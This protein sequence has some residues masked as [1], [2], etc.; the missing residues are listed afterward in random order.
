[1]LT[2]QFQFQP[3]AIIELD[4]VVYAVYFDTESL[5]DFPILA[6]VDSM[7]FVKDPSVIKKLENEEEFASLYGYVFRGHEDLLVSEIPTLEPGQEAVEYRSVMDTMEAKLD[8]KGKEEGMAWILDRDVQ[9]AFLAATLTGQPIS[10]D[11]L[12]DTAWYNMST[13]GQRNFMAEFYADNDAFQEKVANNISS[14]RAKIY[15]QG[16]KGDITSLTS[17]LAFGVASQAYTPEEVDLYIDYIGDN[18]FLTI[19]GG[20][21]VL[22]PE[23]R[24]YIDQFE[25]VQGKSTAQSLI[26]S[27]LGSEA[28]A[29]FMDDGT[30]L[31]YAGMI[32]NGQTDM[33]NTELQS[34][35]DNMFPAFKGSKYSTWNNYYSNRAS[36]IINGTSGNQIVDLTTKQKG[37]VNDLIIQSNGDY[38]EFDKLIRKQY[39]DAPGVKNAIIEGMLGR[40]PQAVSG[41]F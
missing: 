21:Q 20:E 11:D 15:G 32:N 9:T 31:R 28:V 14:I 34:L 8:A 23:L 13:E 26:K 6:K 35:H 17:T 10:V 37:I 24:Q 41:V 7:N 22:P 29:G 33:V 38:Q 18:T 19:A 30:L 12:K 36:K 2:D 5:G 27:Y 16:F 39:R 25:T 1:M 3:D 40:V 4:G